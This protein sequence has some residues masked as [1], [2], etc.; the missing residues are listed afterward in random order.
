MGRQ[1]LLAPIEW[2]K[3]GWF[4]LPQDFDITQPIKQPSLAGDQIKASFN[5]DFGKASLNPEWEFFGEYDPSRFYLEDNTLDIQAKGSVLA[6]CSPLLLMPADHSYTAE[7]EL[8]IEG[9]A[10]GGLVL[11]YSNMFAS[12]ILADKSNILANLRG[13]QFAT[14]KGVIDQHVYLKLRN[15]N[16]IVDMFYSLDGEKWMKIESSMEVS[17]YHH[18]VL[19]GFLSL[20]IGLVSMGEGNVKFSNFKYEPINNSSL[21]FY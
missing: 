15:V 16:H 17:A 14:E 12:G 18:N 10:I 5:Y 9:D 1:T 6:D 21:V 4:K 7:V 11:Y 13:W 3:D 2:T 8:E 20:R 19:G